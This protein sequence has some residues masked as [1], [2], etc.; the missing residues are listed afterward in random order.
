MEKW[1]ELLS[2]QAINWMLTYLLLVTVSGYHILTI[3]QAS[4]KNN[5]IYTTATP[6]NLL[7]HIGMVDCVCKLDAIY[8][9]VHRFDIRDRTKQAV[10]NINM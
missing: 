10:I 3:A 1:N 9:S 5:G 4:S 6:I 2:F 7:I 8:A